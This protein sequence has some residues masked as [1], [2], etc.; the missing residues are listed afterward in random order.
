MTI[1]K[2]LVQNTAINYLSALVNIVVGLILLPFILHTIGKELYGIYLLVLV[3]AG[4]LSIMEIGVGTATVK[5]ISQHLARDEQKEINK[6]F[7]NSI[8]FYTLIGIIICAFLLLAAFFLLG[9]FKVPE[10]Y[11]PIAKNALILAGLASLVVWPLSLFGKI[12]AGMQRYIVTSGCTALFALGRLFVILFF[13]KRGYGLLFLVI[14]YFLTQI[15]LNLIFLVYAYCKLN[16]LRWDFSLISKKVYQKIFSFG[17]VLF[18]IQ[19]C[20]LLIYSTDK[21][22]IGLFLPVASI[23]LYEG[24]FRVHQGVR[25]INALTSSAAIPAISSL[26]ARGSMEK[27]KMVFLKGSKYTAFL[28]LPLTVSVIIFARYIVTYWI[29][30]GYDSVIFPMQLFVSYLALNCSFAL[31]GA[32][33]VAINRMKYLL[34]YAVAGAIAN[35]I[36]SLILVHYMRNFVGVIWGTVIP[37]FVGFPIFLVFFLRL[38]KIRLSE[39]FKRIILPAYPYIAIP[40]ALGILLLRTRPPQ[41]LMET[42]L[43][44]AGL[45]LSYWIVIFFQGLEAYERKD[46]KAITLGI[47]RM[48]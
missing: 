47:L 1:K 13:L 40:I 6:L 34:W 29:G 2:T 14:V 45:L 21:V 20:G 25:L 7:I 42:G 43:Y 19:I 24:A 35:L 5:Y 28:V 9:F 30:P 10:E 22:I 18:V 23:A 3:L 39:F 41:S 37:Y 36:L 32:V 16:F 33:L 17:W 31:S 8:L 44:M 38:V 4:Y 11:L 12:V 27:I 46:L 48:R 15:L 26:N